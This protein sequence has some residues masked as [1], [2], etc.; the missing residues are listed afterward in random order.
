M[1]MKPRKKGSKNVSAK[2]NKKKISDLTEKQ[3]YGKGFND[4]DAGVPP[5][6]R[7]KEYVRGYRFGASILPH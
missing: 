5:R 7:A 6:S 1:P 4:G 2:S 3:K